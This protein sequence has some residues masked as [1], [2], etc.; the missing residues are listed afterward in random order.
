MAGETARLL[1]KDGWP[2]IA[3]SLLII[4]HTRIDQVMLGQ[5]PVRWRWV[6]TVRP[7]V[8]RKPG[9]FVPVRSSRP[10]CLILSSYGAQSCAVPATP[11]AAL[12]RNVLDRCDRRNPHPA[13]GPA[14][15]R[16]SVWRSVCRCLCAAGI[17]D[18]DRHFH[19]PGSSA[20]IW[21][22]SANLQITA[23]STI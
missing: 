5:M 17:H 15:H 19:R 4:I 22:I 1:L 6:S 16:A 7:S 10:S 2:L 18:M 12:Q 11:D 20:G 14:S 13:R 3:S 21:M 23:C 9:C 8:F